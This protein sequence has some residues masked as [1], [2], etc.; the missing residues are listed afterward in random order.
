MPG[1]PAGLSGTHRMYGI[2]RC[3]SDFFDQ[4]QAE[5]IPITREVQLKARDVA[6]EWLRSNPLLEPDVR[7][8]LDAYDAR[9]AQAQAQEQRPSAANE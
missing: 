7:A 9:M 6:I 1:Q 3:L 8:A 4:C 2:A 5:G